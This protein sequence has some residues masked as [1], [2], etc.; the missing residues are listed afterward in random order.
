MNR[1]TEEYAQIQ[2]DAE[3]QGRLYTYLTQ[4]VGRPSP[5]FHARRMV[6]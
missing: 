4:Y 1:L 5:L 2:H 6:S 3:F